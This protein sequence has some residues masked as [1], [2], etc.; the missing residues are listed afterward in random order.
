V[1]EVLV[2]AGGD[3]VLVHGIRVLGGRLAVSH[4]LLYICVC[5]CVCVFIFRRRASPWS[6]GMARCR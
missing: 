6:S 4:F 1:G 5:V 3:E 2:L